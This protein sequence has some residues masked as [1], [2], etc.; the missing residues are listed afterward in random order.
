MSES[1]TLLVADD[2]PGLRESLQRTLTRAGYQRRPRVRTAAPR[3]STIQ[4]GGLD[5]I[6]S[7][8]KMPGLTGIELLR[9]A[10]ALAPDVDVILL[11][12]FGTIEEAVNA[13]KDGAYDF[14]TKPF[15]GEQLLKVVGKALERRSL[16]EQNRV[17]PEAARGP[18][19]PRAR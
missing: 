1:P 17:A 5:L 3:S 10:K 16:I 18:P 4:G 2:D 6:L 11:T 14:I 13:M 12:A 8:L 19:R 7:D 9:A 15:R